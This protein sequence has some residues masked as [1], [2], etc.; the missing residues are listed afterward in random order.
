M[1]GCRSRYRKKAGLYLRL[2]GTRGSVPTPE[3]GNARYGGNTPCLELRPNEDDLLILDAGIGLHWLGS[4]LMTGDFGRGKGTAHIFVSHTHWGHIQ[5]I[6]FFHPL[7][8]SGNH[9]SIYGCSGKSGESFK[10]CL[11]EQ[12]APDYCPV[13]N[14]FDDNIGALTKIEEIGKCRLE[15]P[16]ANEKE[17]VLGSPRVTARRVNH[18][19]DLGTLGFRIETDDASVAYIPDVEYL[20]E[21]NKA[22]SLA[23][24][25]GVNLL[26]HDS[27][28]TNDA[29]PSKRGSGHSSAC[30]ALEIA[31]RA[32]ARRLVLFHHHPD[33]TD[34]AINEILLTCQNT[35]FRVEAAAEGAEYRL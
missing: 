23:L 6:P 9:F 20:D 33:R 25:D 16:G 2:W 15:T 10:E 1:R 14:F 12:M 29:H 31:T 19:P 21:S 4:D 3:A 11:L 34:A 18:V 22:P 17:L 7:L 27:H 24:A 35:D 5:G 28:H 13:P 26:I 32:G 30:D 8:I